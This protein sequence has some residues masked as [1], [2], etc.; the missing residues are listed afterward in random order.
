[1]AI[2]CGG[3][4]VQAIGLGMRTPSLSFGELPSILGTRPTSPSWGNTL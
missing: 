1:M 4:G 3:W 2:A